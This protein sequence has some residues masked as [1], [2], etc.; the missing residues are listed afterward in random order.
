MM[1]IGVP[2]VAYRVPGSQ[3]ADWY[4][5]ATVRLGYTGKLALQP[6]FHL[7]VA[8]HEGLIST[9]GCIAKESFFLGLKLMTNWP[10]KLLE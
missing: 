8:T 10:T 2:K 7:F 5:F 6:F 3:Q 4:V 1:P 9:I